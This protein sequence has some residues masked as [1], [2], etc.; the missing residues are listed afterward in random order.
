MHKDEDA[1]K[2]KVVNP[3]RSLEILF[4]IDNKIAVFFDLLSINNIFG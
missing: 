3:I 1:M 4:F 2:G